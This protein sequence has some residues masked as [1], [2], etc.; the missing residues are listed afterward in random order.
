MKTEVSFLG[1]NNVTIVQTIIDRL[2]LTPKEL[3]VC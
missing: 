1:E 3:I 2:S